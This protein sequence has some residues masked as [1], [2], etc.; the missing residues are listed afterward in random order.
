MQKH[1]N[2]KI[3]ELSYKTQLDFC[4]GVMEEVQTSVDP[5]FLTGLSD[6]R[7][8]RFFFINQGWRL[9]KTGFITVSTHYITY[10]SKHPSNKILTGK[11]LL[12][13]DK[14]VQGPWY[15]FGEQLAIFDQKIHF[16]IQ[17][18]GGNLNDFLEFK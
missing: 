17:M 9:T 18:L 4:Y 13:M 14:C 16:E 3:L 6:D 15:I 12:N 2:Q 8:K 10:F 7:I 1:K 11:I 5:H